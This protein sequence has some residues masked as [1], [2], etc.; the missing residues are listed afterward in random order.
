MALQALAASLALLVQG[1]GTAQTTAAPVVFYEAVFK[2]LKRSEAQYAYLGPVGP[3]YP[4]RASADGIRGGA[5]IDCRVQEGGK[6][7]E[8]KAAAEKPAG[9]GFPDAAL[10]MARRGLI[11]VGPEAPL[12]EIVHVRVM[13][14]PKMK[15]EV[16]H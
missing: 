1:P 16:E 14:D 15:A 3:Y 7:A 4:E 6:L 9:Y 12:G 13:F 2:P 8:C 5:V 11:T 10:I